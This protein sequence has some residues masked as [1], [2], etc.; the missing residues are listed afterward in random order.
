MRHVAPSSDKGGTRRSLIRGLAPYAA[1]IAAAVLWSGNYVIA[2]AALSSSSPL[3][4]AFWRWT[5]TFAVLLPFGAPGLWRARG[6]LRAMLPNW[7]LLSAVGVAGG[8][9]CLYFALADISALDTLVA[10][11]SK[12]VLIALLVIGLSGHIL[13]LRHVAGAALPAF[14]LFYIATQ[15]GGPMLGSAW[16]SAGGWL[17]ANIALFALYS[18]LVARMPRDRTTVASFTAIVGL[19]TIMLLPFYACEVGQRGSIMP[20]RETILAATYLGLG[21]SA[22]AYLLWNWSL[23]CLGAAEV[24]PL[25][26]LVPAIGVAEAILMLG[27]R[28][29]AYHVWG[30]VGIAA[31]MIIFAWGR[32]R[33]PVA[34]AAP[35]VGSAETSL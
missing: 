35:T 24:G 4:L 22:A 9:T 30:A 31:G 10:A 2:K 5:I 17:F 21:A 32:R 27:E 11:A 15:G 18:V 23:R 7:L 1:A 29:Q 19:G 16:S 12:P 34:T 8:N 26:H 33:K 20:A 13:E 14:G 25:L 28:L 3:E 6:R